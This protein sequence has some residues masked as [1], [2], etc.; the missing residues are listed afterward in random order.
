MT[1]NNPFNNDGT[2]LHFHVCMRQYQTPE[3]SYIERLH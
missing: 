1:K 3:A 2:R